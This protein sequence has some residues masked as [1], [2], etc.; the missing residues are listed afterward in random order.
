MFLLPHSLYQSGASCPPPHPHYIPQSEKNVSN[1]LHVAHCIQWLNDGSCKQ[2]CLALDVP[3]CMMMMMAE[4]GIPRNLP[5]VYSQE[6]W[7]H[8]CVSKNF[9]HQHLSH[10]GPF[11]GID[12]RLCC[13]RSVRAERNHSDRGRRGKRGGKARVRKTQETRQKGDGEARWDIGKGGW[14]NRQSSYWQQWGLLTI[15]EYCLKSICHRGAVEPVIMMWCSAFHSDNLFSAPVHLTT[16]LYKGH[17]PLSI[18]V[19]QAVSLLNYRAQKL[20]QS[21]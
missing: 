7:D 15:Q 11:R 20:L 6:G 12:E 19:C 17:G 13:T 5:P 9:L 14:K 1:L 18:P 8:L 21:F 4:L 2:G 10:P 3:I 16:A